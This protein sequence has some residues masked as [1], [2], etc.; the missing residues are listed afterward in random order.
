LQ[1]KDS[2]DEAHNEIRD[3]EKEGFQKEVADLKLK[4]AHY[5]L[6]EA[7]FDEE[8]THRI[9]EIAN[10]SDEIVSLKTTLE[11]TISNSKHKIQ[12]TD[13]SLEFELLRDST[14]QHLLLGSPTDGEDT[15]QHDLMT[16]IQ[17]YDDR[18]KE[19]DQTIDK[20]KQTIDY[21]F[22][23]VHELQEMNEMFN[24]MKKGEM[25]ETVTDSDDGKAKERIRHESFDV[26]F[27]SESLEPETMPEF[28]QVT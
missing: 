6:L 16:E 17:N 4:V 27:L 5:E 2:S 19:K 7:A 20:L 15:V 9:E 10:L 1:V 26:P 18:L 23:L 22:Y 8:L 11:E 28:V 24:I 25:K 14:K 3:C 21:N 13:S 12:R